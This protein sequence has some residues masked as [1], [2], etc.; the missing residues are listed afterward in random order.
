MHLSMLPQLAKTDCE[1]GDLAPDA[2]VCKLLQTRTEK[3]RDV[4]RTTFA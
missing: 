3:T 4:E 1:A 2:I